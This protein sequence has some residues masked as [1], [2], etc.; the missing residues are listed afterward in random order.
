MSNGIVFYLGNN[1][2]NGW[3][4]QS[5]EHV[6]HGLR[7]FVKDGHWWM[8]Y[9]RQ[10]NT[11]NVCIGRSGYIDWEHPINKIAN[12]DVLNQLPVPDNVSTDDHYKLMQWAKTVTH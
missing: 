7:G 3:W 5:V 2:A 1:A 4:V 6:D 9:N 11:I 10:E 12:V 8:D